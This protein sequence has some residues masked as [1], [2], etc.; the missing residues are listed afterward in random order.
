[1]LAACSAG[2]GNSGGTGNN[3]GGSGQQTLTVG[4]GAAPANLDFT[5]TAGAAIPQA[6]MYNV[7]EG[8]VKLDEHADVKPLLATSWKISDGGTK[9][10]FTL[11]SGV[12]FSNG[13]PFNA[14]VVKFSLDRVPDWKA[15]TPT[16]LSA[17]RSVSV[18][19]PTEVMI[20][21][22][23]P[24]NNLLFW[25]AGPLGAMFSPNAVDDLA[26]TA[27]GTGPYL[28]D[29]YNRGESLILKRNDNYWGTEA[30]L[31]TATLRYYNDANAPVNA[32][33]SGDLD[34][35]YQTQAAD[36]VKQFQADDQYN[37]QIGATTG[38]TVM[39]M[40]NARPPFNDRRVRLA[41][42]Y[43]VDRDAIN[44]TATNGY[45]KVLGGPVAPTDPWYV[46]LSKKYPYDPQK[47]KQL[48]A[49]A[50]K[51]KLTVD[52]TVPSLPYAQTIA[53]VVKSDLAKIGVTANL[54]T[55]EFPAVWLDKTFT[56]HDYDLTVINHVEARNVFN[57]AD[58]SYYWSY[59][60][61]AVQKQL[62]DAVAAPS[63]QAFVAGMKTA[64]NGIVDDAAADWLYNAPNIVIAKKSVAGV[65]A[66]D[67]GVSLDLTKA[68]NPK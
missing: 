61:K 43:G 49:E 7:Y 14:D 12:K 45:G 2:A 19:S 20:N 13:D 38:I 44:T 23:Q 67:T 6:L 17:I 8:L 47:A 26:T 11:R 5:Q 15:N 29:R 46:D 42:I 52:F 65:N 50:G 59:R 21:L 53:Q 58:P 30:Q 34:V 27:I 68:S 55:Q 40:N 32:L 4:L 25:L 37:V 60:N 10:D 51:S 54:Q 28:L 18:V 24:D 57:Y 22:K 56:Q 16:Y 31:A 62:T 1:M 39:S 36:Q 33:R 64:V 66:D 9:Y 41:I 48:L 3:T 63:Q 35:V